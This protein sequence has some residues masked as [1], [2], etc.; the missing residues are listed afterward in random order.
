[1]KLLQPQNSIPDVF[2][3]MISAG[4]RIAYYRCPANFVLWSS[5]LECRGRFAGKLETIEL[6]AS[7]CCCTVL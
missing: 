7:A 5:K 1:M 2:I 3:W 4:K 6:K